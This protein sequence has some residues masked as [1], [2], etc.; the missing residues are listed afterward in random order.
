ML[1][2]PIIRP[3]DLLGTS[4]DNLA[5]NERHVV[6]SSADRIFV[7]QLGPFFKDSMK[8]TNSK[9][10]K[11]LEYGKDY[12]LLHLLTAATEQTTREVNS[13]V[14]I[15]NETIAEVLIE[16]QAI[17]GIYA[18]GSIALIEI[19][20]TFKNS[21]MKTIKWVDIIGLPDAF[22]V[23]PHKHI[24]FDI[25]ELEKLNSAL[26]S[27]YDA[28]VERDT[29][30]FSELYKALDLNI[31]NMNKSMLN[32]FAVLDQTLIRIESNVLFREGDILVTDS[33][34]HPKDRYG[35]G[36]WAHH[37]DTFLYGKTLNGNSDVITN[38]SYE[39]GHVARKT[40]FWEQLSEINDIS[41][42]ITANKTNID[43]GESVIFTLRTTGLPE[44]TKIDYV[45]TGVTASDIEGGLLTGSF[46]TDINGL[47]NVTI[48]TTMDRSS[49]GDEVLYLQLN[50][51]KSI[52]ASVTI[53][54]T[55][56]APTYSI[57]FTSDREGKN[58]IT[59][60]NEGDSFYVN[61]KTTELDDGKSINIYYN[62]SKTDQFDFSSELPT[63]IIVNNNTAS[64][65]V[66]V[67]NDIITEGNEN[68]IVTLS[69]SN[70]ENSLVSNNLRINDTSKAPVF[71]IQYSLSN[72]TI[73]NI[74][75]VNE[76]VSFYACVLTE[77]VPN[78]TVLDVSYSGAINASDIDGTLLTS[79]TINNSRG[80]IPIKMRL[81]QNSEGNEILTV[82][83][84][85][86]GNR[87]A[88]KNIT[89]NDTSTNPNATMKFST[90]T[91]G[92]NTITSANEG[93]IVYLIVNT[94]DVANGTEFNVVYE[95][96]ATD[97]DFDNARPT[98]VKINNNGATITFNIKE[99]YL[100]DGDKTLT[101]RLI[102]KSNND[103][104]ASATLAIV[105]SSKT[106]TYDIL[107]S[108]TQN[109]DSVITSANEGDVIYA[110]LKTTDVPDNTIMY[111]NTTIG[112]DIANIAN[113]DVI[114][115]VATT[116]TVKNNIAYIQIQLSADNKNEG[117]EDIV[118][119]VSKTSGGTIVKSA[120]ILLNDTS[121]SPTYTVRIRG[122]D[123][124]DKPTVNS[125]IADKIL[126]GGIYAVFVNTTN[127]PNGT[128]LY[129][130]RNQDDLLPA[131]KKW[132]ATQLFA[133]GGYHAPASAI[134][135]NGLAVFEFATTI[136]EIS[137]IPDENFVLGLSIYTQSS[138]GTSISDNILPIVKPIFNNYFANLNSLGALTYVNEGT[139][140]RYITELS[141]V[142]LNATVYQRFYIKNTETAV[143]DIG[144]SE[145]KVFKTTNN[146]LI[147]TFT[148]KADLLTEG[149]EQ[150]SGQTRAGDDRR[151]MGGAQIMIEDTSRRGSKIRAGVANGSNVNIFG[152][153]LEH[154]DP[155]KYAILL[156]PEGQH[157]AWTT[158][159][160]DNKI[161]AA[162]VVFNRSGTSRIGYSGNVN[163]MVIDMEKGSA[164][165][166]SDVWQ[167]SFHN[168]VSTKMLTT[169]KGTIP[170]T[171]NAALLSPYSQHETWIYTNGDFTILNRSGTNN[172][173]Y[174][175]KTA[176]TEMR[177]YMPHETAHVTAA[178]PRVV[179]A[180]I[181]DKG[182]IDAYDLFKYNLSDTSKYAVF[183]NPLITHEAWSITRA[184]NR[185][186]WTVWDRSG[187]NRINMSK[188][189]VAYCVVQL[190]A[191]GN[192]DNTN[193]KIFHKPGVYSFQ[194]EKDKSYKVTVIGGGGA[195]GNAIYYHS[196]ATEL[197]GETGADVSLN[198]SEGAK[199][200]AY[201]GKGGTRGCW[202]NGSA[203]RDGVSGTGGNTAI[204]RVTGTSSIL[205]NSTEVTKGGN[206]TMAEYDVGSG[207]IN[208]LSP[209]KVGFNNGGRGVP[210][211]GSRQLGFGGSGGAG[212]VIVSRFKSLKNQTGTIT[213]G[214]IAQPYNDPTEYYQSNWHYAFGEAG[215]GGMVIIEQIA[216]V[217]ITTT[218]LAI[219]A[220][221]G[222]NI[223]RGYNLSEEF[224]KVKS[225][226]PNS[227]DNIEL[228]ILSNWYMVG[229]D[230][231]TA[232]ITIDENC[233]DANS[234]VINNNG[235]ILGRGSDGIGI[236]AVDYFPTISPKIK[237][238]PGILN[239][240]TKV[241]TIN[242][243]GIIAGGGGGGARG[244]FYGTGGGGA[245]YGTGGS[246]GN[247]NSA[248]KLGTDAT[249]TTPG[250]G[251]YTNSSNYA[252]D[253]G[254]WG[255]VGGSSS[256]T[257]F[258][259]PSSTK[260]TAPGYIKVGNVTINN[261]SGG[262]TIGLT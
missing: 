45:L 94:V 225:R 28:V 189:K 8:I 49:E 67:K 111:F 68:L 249:L 50:E 153:T 142:A 138:G 154:L 221:T 211:S 244:L 164:S 234:I 174:S 239:T 245:P 190:K 226:Y 219:T 133:N 100:T 173:S 7:P 192:I 18:E 117:N 101:V 70:Y 136:S 118:V 231:S 147:T 121:V 248:T 13:V 127:V 48:K 139:R 143:N 131:N 105:D 255:I 36:E 141:D 52:R 180:G 214:K 123:G 19:I 240:S 95:G 191:D 128:A 14:Y 75:S 41:Y 114:T 107:F 260:G 223:T 103:E 1:F 109:G 91:S 71:N 53:R 60:V 137:R 115:N 229:S 161:N 88:T 58:I 171:G 185:I 99:D 204:N 256:D 148:V 74:E 34:V 76:G 178:Y 98:S 66:D 206:G 243:Y 258:N 134:V 39:P 222:T 51:F 170:I 30:R 3:L 73:G 196:G 61:I 145:D 84:A 176:L 6:N 165:N 59:D 151:L 82:N 120:K 242:N 125:P 183:I 126:I 184:Q 224:K 259:T 81:D 203:Y 2:T 113:G 168:E 213:I 150:L 90:N 235:Y 26:T 25:V 79:V 69:L 172:I 197:P 27:I 16:Y 9:N 33:P 209:E 78:N 202:N 38:I 46:I 146:R 64:F 122:G 56:R 152:D 65:K 116:A 54:D 85:L 32:N 217:N 24:G 89:I 15:T 169:A 198:I 149:R 247:P 175:G 158:T 182:Y 80:Y 31:E 92:S 44:G 130:R 108:K 4:A 97:N 177:S 11:L 205:I 210:G 63:S 195:G 160:S 232:G 12:K 135:N 253:G 96:S 110:V 144:I 102:H 246:Y 212:G 236:N 199:F 156:C 112:G 47:A 167:S 17:G 159:V 129:L 261:L 55:S 257:S 200:T 187:T 22:P 237:A 93:A 77:N 124:T 208:P 238:G 254:E 20:D 10:G 194:F 42:I 132:I 106:S 230:S 119:S 140:I 201:G 188:I 181:T 86:N 57:L 207:G 228:N 262:K 104:L 252:G 227:N 179:M 241:P 157:E 37:V 40:H 83:L 21:K 35:Y 233:N 5:I 72:I 62:G 216:E 23:T 43:E 166:G 29:P 193:R 250:K 163:W 155:A 218:K 87:V 215:G 186:S 220:T 251:G 162:S